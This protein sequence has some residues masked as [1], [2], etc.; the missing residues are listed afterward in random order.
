MSLEDIVPWSEEQEAGSC[1]TLSQ[2]FYD[3]LAQ[4][5]GER[6]RQCAPRVPV[7]T[8]PFNPSVL[9]AMF[10]LRYRILWSR[11]W[12][13]FAPSR[14]GLHRPTFCTARGRRPSCRTTN[15]ERGRRYIHGRSQKS[16]NCSPRFYHLARGSCR[17]DV[18]WQRSGTSVYH[19]TGHQEKDTHQD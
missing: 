2:D 12:L 5:I 16:T 11:S 9:G 13:P 4:A 1:T 17:V 14:A 6:I 8:G 15:L 7:V 10:T 3:T 18:L 19:G